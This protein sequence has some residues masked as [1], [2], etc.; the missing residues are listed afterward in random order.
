M[1]KSEKYSHVV[2]HPSVWD[3]QKQQVQ[4]ESTKV[5]A[6]IC[7]SVPYPWTAYRPS[8]SPKQWNQI[9]SCSNPGEAFSHAECAHA[10]DQLTTETFSKCKSRE[11]IQYEYFS[12]VSGAEIDTSLRAL[13]CAEFGQRPDQK[14]GRT[15]GSTCLHVKDANLLLENH[16][17]RLH[18]ASCS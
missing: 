5:T 10:D 2:L 13:V 12:K 9:K 1:H 15:N 14:W 16:C 11:S 3:R 4:H 17:R 7:K 18:E 8:T 6:S